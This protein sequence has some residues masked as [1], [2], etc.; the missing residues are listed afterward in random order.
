MK[1]LA[2]LGSTGSIGESTLD[3]VGRFPD[4]FRVHSLAA[5]SSRPE[6][7]ARQVAQTGAALVSVPT[8]A[9]A[10][11]LAGLLESRAEVVWGTEGLV[12]AVAA[13]EVDLVVSAIVGAAGLVPTYAALL[14]G[15]D[16]AVANKETLV[17]AGE[18]VMEAASR[19]GARLLPVDSEHSALFQALEGRDAAE[20]RRLILT[21]SG[22]PFRGRSAG[23]LARVG[24]QEALA[25]PRWAMGPKITVDS[26][27]LMNKGLEVIEA[28]WLFGV[29][30]DRID[31]T[32]HPQSVVH[33]LVEFIDGSL[34]AQLGVADMRGPI[35]YAL[36][37]PAR[38]P[39]PD[40]TL[41]LWQ[42]GP[43]TFEPPDREAFPCL[44]LAYG[45]LRAGGTAP[46]VLSGANEAAVEAFLGDRLS[47]PGIPAAVD[48][49]LQAHSPRPLDSVHTALEVDR[50]ARSFVRAWIAERGARSAT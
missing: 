48:A 35:A 22:G 32:L 34:L 20:V 26:A 17:A 14:E 5:G 9:D 31:V 4:R 6:R 33:S 2:L 7:L 30:A 44:D 19:S 43:L 11:R 29:P 15:K 37:Y 27:T 24:V 12:R 40:L 45:A 50:W 42:A 1:G 41:D 13:P 49:A 38:L 46:A 23:S 10:R 28:H 21:A 16:V 25:H 18:L 47:F 39:L 36:H 3:V 8:E